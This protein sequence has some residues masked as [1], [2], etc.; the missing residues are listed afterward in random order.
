VWLIK[1]YQELQRKIIKIS[2][3][4]KLLSVTRRKQCEDPLCGQ[5]R[6]RKIYNE[7]WLEMKF[8]GRIRFERWLFKVEEGRNDLQ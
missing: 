4:K 7:E 5:E 8:F 2:C 3:K 6:R 1:R